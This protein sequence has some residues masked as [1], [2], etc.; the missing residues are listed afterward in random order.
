MN[1]EK[2]IIM[3]LLLVVFVIL[4]VVLINKKNSKEGKPIDYNDIEIHYSQSG[5]G[6]N[7]EYMSD[8]ITVILSNNKS[9]IRFED[10]I[11]KKIS[12]N[13]EEYS[14]LI[15]L[16]NNKFYKLKKD[17][18]IKNVYDGG[19]AYITVIDNKSGKSH[20]VGGT[21]VDNEIFEEIEDKI[22]DVIGED[23]ISDFRKTEL[24]DYF[25]KSYN[26][27]LSEWGEDD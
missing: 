15:D 7:P 20:T 27:Y 9:E 3:I 14:E 4:I 1:I 21:A 22:I 13:K 8:T 26:D 25:E 18:S 11:S 12:I 17:L 23:T 24:K 2:K 16:I 10:E 19:S 6:P 5:G